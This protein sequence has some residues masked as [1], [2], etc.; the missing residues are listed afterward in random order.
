LYVNNRLKTI[1][2]SGSRYSIT[3]LPT[4]LSLQLQQISLLS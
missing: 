2:S 4:L 1:Q 3:I